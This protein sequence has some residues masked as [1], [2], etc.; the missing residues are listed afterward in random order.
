MTNF[1]R[2]F[3]NAQLLRRARSNPNY[4]DYDG[5]LE[6]DVSRILENYRY[7]WSYHDSDIP[8]R[9]AKTIIDNWEYVF[10]SNRTVKVKYINHRTKRLILNENN[11]PYDTIDE[12]FVVCD[13]SGA[14]S[15]DN[16]LEYISFEQVP[17]ILICNM[18]YMCARCSSLQEVNFGELDLS[19]CDS[20]SYA[21]GDCPSLRTFAVPSERAGHFYINVRRMN[22]MFK[23]CTSLTNICL[24]NLYLHSLITVEGM[25]KNCT[26]LVEASLNWHVQD[27]SS[28][29][30]NH[31]ELFYNC[32]NLERVYLTLGASSKNYFAQQ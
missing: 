16:I 30:M 5:R 10:F 25:F 9:I 20:M 22:G 29:K 1:G 13:W 27:S 28:K 15:D 23:N 32:P 6:A 17:N 7:E 12:K 4:K 2:S 3:S 19:F 11:R 26:A 21:F 31:D 24:T 18:D 14:F 8:T